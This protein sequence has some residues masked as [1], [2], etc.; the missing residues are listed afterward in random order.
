MTYLFITFKANGKTRRSWALQIRA[1]ETTRPGLIGTYELVD[2]SG[3][4]KSETVT[5]RASG[6]RAK[7]EK[8]YE[9]GRKDTTW[10]LRNDDVESVRYAKMNNHY[11]ELE[12]L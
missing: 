6:P 9:D 4:Q 12:L 7:V 5:F 2:R 3:D 11:G 10:L 8:T 1:E